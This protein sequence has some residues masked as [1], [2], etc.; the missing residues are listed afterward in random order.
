MLIKAPALPQRFSLG[1]ESRE[2]RRFREPGQEARRAPGAEARPPPIRKPDRRKIA[3]PGSPE[4]RQP[5]NR[6]CG[7]AAL[8]VSG[9]FQ[10][11]LRPAL[12]LQTRVLMRLAA[13]ECGDPLHEIEQALRRAAFLLQDGL[14]DFRRL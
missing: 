11:S 2:S 9:A 14:D 5:R 1:L 13:S 7:R 6:I 3:K 12:K 4:K 8:D 10:Q